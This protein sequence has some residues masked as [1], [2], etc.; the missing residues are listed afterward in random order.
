[1]GTA[2]VAR[3]KAKPTDAI[4]KPVAVAVRG[5]E[6]WRAWLE[7]AA[8]HCRMSVSAFLDYAATQTAKQQGFTD[9]P[10]ER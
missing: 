5:S 7:A 2:T 8:A 9:P 6:E 10:P 4:R 1:M 3:K